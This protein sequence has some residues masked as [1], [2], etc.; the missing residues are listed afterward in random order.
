MM[1]RMCEW[2]A[3]CT[4]D[5]EFVILHPILGWVPCCQRC[6]D[7]LGIADELVLASTVED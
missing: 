7:R 1:P 5:T 2:F 3:L 4:N 6:A